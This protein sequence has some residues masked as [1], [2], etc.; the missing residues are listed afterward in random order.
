MQED[1]IRSIIRSKL[2]DGELPHVK[3]QVTWFGPGTG[4]TC[5]ACATIIASAHVECECE[6]PDG[7]VLRFHRQCFALWDEMREVFA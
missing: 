7:G 5:V 4:Q 3:C 2:V 6:H 1:E